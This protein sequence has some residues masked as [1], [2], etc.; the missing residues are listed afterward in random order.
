[1]G[2]ENLSYVKSIETHARAF[3]TL[4]ILSIGTVNID[5]PPQDLYVYS[6]DF[7]CNTM[8]V[9]SLLHFLFYLNHP[10]GL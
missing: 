6:N 2:A 3:F 5:N 1:M 8:S 7:D 9:M 4:N 10:L